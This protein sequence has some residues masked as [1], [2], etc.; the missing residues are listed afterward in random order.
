MVSRINGFAL[1]RW[2]RGPEGEGTLR[3]IS[4]DDHV[5]ETPDVWTAR[6]PKKWAD[7]APKLVSRPDGGQSWVIDGRMTAG[8]TAAP[9][10]GLGPVNGPRTWASVPKAGYEPSERLQ[11][12]DREGIAV[13]VLYPGVGGIGGEALGRIA[14]PELETACVQA[15][16]DWLLDVWAKASDRFVPQC[17]V[18]VSSPE[19]AAAE[20]ERS[21]KR[22]HRGIVMPCAPMHLRPGAPHIHD[23][24]WDVLWAA[25]Q[26]LDAPVCWHSG[27]D[28]VILLPIYSAFTPEEAHAFEMVRGP[29]SSAQPLVFFLLSGIGERFPKL[30]MVFADT[31]IAW[32]PSQLELCEH[33]SRKAMLQEREGMKVTPTEIFRRQCSVSLSYD[34]VGL[35]MREAIGVDNILWHSE[36]PMPATTWPDS[37]RAIEQNFNGIPVKDRERVLSTNAARLYKIA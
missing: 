33:Q 26:A 34:S 14:E 12:M 8:P 21:V 22:G 2:E 10:P 16:N 19:A 4:A 29:I 15:Y 20:A 3:I 23:K 31:T 24:K 5:L 30:K 9:W 27:S 32:V 25:A 1:S 35:A 18:P 37:A 7:R 28:A 17:V 11:L 36:F 13:S 6:L